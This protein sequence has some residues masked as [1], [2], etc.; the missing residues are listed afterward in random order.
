[1]LNQNCVFKAI[2]C[3]YYSS[4]DLDID[5]FTKSLINKTISSKTIKELHLNPLNRSS[6]VQS[7]GPKI[8]SKVVENKKED[9]QIGSLF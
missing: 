2:F 7:L 5:I 9:N 4:M 8:I 3:R 6:S 1:M